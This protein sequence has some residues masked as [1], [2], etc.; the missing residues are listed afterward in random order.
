MNGIINDYEGHTTVKSLSSCCHP[1]FGRFATF[2]SELPAGYLKM[3]NIKVPITPE[4]FFRLNE[5]L[6]LF[7]TN[8]RNFFLFLTNPAI[9]EA[10]KVA[11]IQASFVHD[12]VRRGVGLFLFL[13]HKLIYIAL[14]LCKNA[15]KECKVDC[16]EKTGIDPLPF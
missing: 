15:C 12:R 9:L 13:R 8:P 16:D 3:G 2:S 6:H 4:Y 10:S 14:T 11:K 5:S 1:S 7:E